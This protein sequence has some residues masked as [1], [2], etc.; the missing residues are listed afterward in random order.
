MLCSLH[1]SYHSFLPPFLPFLP[2][3]L[4]KPFMDIL[5]KSL[6]SYIVRRRLAGPTCAC[7]IHIAWSSF[8]RRCIPARC[9]NKRMLCDYHPT[10]STFWETS[11]LHKKELTV[12]EFRT[13]I[14]RNRAYYNQSKV[15]LVFF[16]AL[17]RGEPY[18]LA[19]LT[20]PSYTSV[21]K[22]AGTAKVAELYLDFLQ[23]GF[24]QAAA[25]L[26]S[27]SAWG[28]SAQGFR[29]FLQRAGFTLSPLVRDELRQPAYATM[30]RA[31]VGEESLKHRPV[32]IPIFRVLADIPNTLR[33]AHWHLATFWLSTVRSKIRHWRLAHTFK[34]VP[35][36]IPNTDS[37]DVLVQRNP[38]CVSSPV[39]EFKRCCAAAK[40]MHIPSDIPTA[41]LA[42][43]GTHTPLLEMCVRLGAW[44]LA[45][46]SLLPVVLTTEDADHTVM[47]VLMGLATML[48]A[49]PP[50]GSEEH[51]YLR[52]TLLGI[53]ENYDYTLNNTHVQCMALLYKAV[54]R[55][56]HDF[57][58][59]LNSAWVFAYCHEHR[60]ERLLEF[61]AAEYI[62]DADCVSMARHPSVGIL[63][64]LFWETRTVQKRY[65]ALRET[66][67]SKIGTFLLACRTRLQQRL[68]MRQA[69]I[70][71]HRHAW[72]SLVIV[73]RW[74]K[75]PLVACPIC[76]EGPGK[77]M[78]VLHKDRRHAICRE[79][80]AGVQR[81]GKNC[82]PLCR[83]TLG[84]QQPSLANTVN[85]GSDYDE[86]EHYDYVRDLIY[87]S[88]NPNPNGYESDSS[89]ESDSIYYS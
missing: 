15:G 61:L 26:R 64:A 45:L 24:A 81:S 72:E 3:S 20:I 48:E 11:L 77:P 57:Y 21:W 41:W 33:A 51:D 80:L 37:L 66:A 34:P 17:K 1:T 56:F 86:Y 5:K 50:T 35:P 19:L 71:A 8:P 40:A 39:E 31:Y 46:G 30:L 14:I 79:C 12:A 53:L 36:Y 47:N 58:T 70:A 73:W 43:E 7:G 16:H 88:R 9:T 28:L 52:K 22:R 67:C 49:V 75:S 55:D 65:A 68:V 13:E 44:R 63:G 85:I 87:Y 32:H 25:L 23:R 60:S 42:L 2:P 84:L 76:M 54:C 10:L 29:T 78:A 4:R 18:V 6:R 89:Y 69:A 74:W 82:C 27:W 59:F 83:E 38:R 62:T